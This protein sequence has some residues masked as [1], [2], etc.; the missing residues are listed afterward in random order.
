MMKRTILAAALLAMM[1]VTDAPALAQ[2]GEGQS[3]NG[4]AIGY[5]EGGTPPP[6]PKDYALNEDG[7]VVVSGDEVLDCRTFVGAFDE[8]YDE[9]GN[10][11]QA[12][13]VL[14]RCEQ[15][16]ESPKTLQ[17]PDMEALPETGGFPAI[18]IVAGLFLVVMGL[19]TVRR[20]SGLKGR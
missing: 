9:W 20:L 19:F 12:K 8:G 15:M 18:P 16:G 1:L 2:E 4:G 11:T 14:E 7:L 17:P 5:P 3:G 10:Q 13:R 6:P